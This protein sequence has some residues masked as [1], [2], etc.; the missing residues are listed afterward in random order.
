MTEY[1]MQILYAC[2]IVASVGLPFLS[3]W[4]V[5]INAAIPAAVGAACILVWLFIDAGWKGLALFGWAAI[6]NFIIFFG[7]GI[8]GASIG[9]GV[10]SLVFGH[11]KK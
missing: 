8:I 2:V 6:L 11:V 1:G 7:L 10:R 3:R 4:N 5:A 9:Q